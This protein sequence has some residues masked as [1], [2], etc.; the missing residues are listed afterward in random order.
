MTI[1]IMTP[2]KIKMIVLMP[3]ILRH[4]SFS[5]FAASSCLIADHESYCQDCP[6]NEEESE[7][8]NGNLCAATTSALCL[9]GR[10]RSLSRGST[11]SIPLLAGSLGRDD[12]ALTPTVQ[13]DP[14]TKAASLRR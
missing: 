1:P 8:V 7:G 11:L 13:D 14:A 5:L 3:F 9:C 10:L 12:T 6:A 2:M 4:H